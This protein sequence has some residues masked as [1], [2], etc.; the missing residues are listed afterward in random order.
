VV[1][2]QST[3]TQRGQARQHHHKSGLAARA[4]CCCRGGAQSPHVGVQLPQEQLLQPPCSHRPVQ[5]QRGLPAVPFG[6]VRLPRVRGTVTTSKLRREVAAERGGRRTK[7]R[8]QQRWGL[9]CLRI[10][11]DGEGDA[12]GKRPL[13]CAC[14]IT[15]SC[16]PS[17]CRSTSSTPHGPSP[18]GHWNQFNP[19]GNERCAPHPGLALEATTLS[20]RTC[21]PACNLLSHSRP[22]PSSID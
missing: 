6:L 11:G 10:V 18:V 20:T 3:G 17:R 7:N 5:T 13:N 2:S 22:Q 8:G 15:L 14:P 16:C 12:D 1:H 19:I 21:Q 9:P 4:K